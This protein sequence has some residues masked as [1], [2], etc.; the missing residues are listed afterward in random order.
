LGRLVREDAFREDL[1]IIGS[2]RCSDSVGAFRAIAGRIPAIV[3]AVSE[4]NAAGLLLATLGVSV[5]ACTSIIGLPDLPELSPDNSSGASK[6]GA[7][8]SSGQGHSTGGSETASGAQNVGGVAGSGAS[9]SGGAESGEGGETGAACA[10]PCTGGA[11][12]Q[13]G[14]CLCGQ[15]ELLCEGTCVDVLND[16]SN[17]GTC[18]KVCSET[19]NLGRCVTTLPMLQT[20]G[21]GGDP[22]G[23][24]WLVVSGDTIYFTSSTGDF[25]CSANRDGSMV[26]VLA[27]RQI[28]ARA[29]TFDATNIYWAN[30]GN[31]AGGGKIMKLPKAG[32]EAVQLAA[33]DEFSPLVLA[34][35]GNFV[36]WG[37]PDAPIKKVPIAGG[38][39]T[40]VSTDPGAQ[41]PSNLLT[42]GMELFWSNTLDGGSIFKLAL[43]S[44][45]AISL[46][47]NIAGADDYDRLAKSGANLYF[48]HRPAGQDPQLAKISTAGSEITPVAAITGS[49][50]VVDDTAAYVATNSGIVRVS[51]DGSSTKQLVAGGAAYNLFVD[52]NDLYWRESDGIF[53]VT[54]KL[55]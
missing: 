28:N 15:G 53:R 6:G 19:C 23:A 5:V 21:I 52:E 41:S 12:C 18:K 35:D 10:L 49:S 17:C 54:S 48:L 29:L 22:E 38:T 24:A 27:S 55:P 39:P 37:G 42:D 11:T 16:S 43:S 8:A 45:S 46:G 33:D 34:I 44:T 30:A 13:D 50:L 9:M 7:V 47:S 26:T 20:T 14:E 32:G 25:V 51:L 36:Y 40:T 31:I 3:G 1:V 2:T 4:M